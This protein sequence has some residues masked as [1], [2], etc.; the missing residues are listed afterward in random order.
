M[1]QSMLLASNKTRRG[2]FGKDEKRGIGFFFSFFSYTGVVLW[3]FGF[4]GVV[5]NYVSIFGLE[6]NA[7]FGSYS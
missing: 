2:L 7:K 3:F 5:L 4:I 6:F 1:Q